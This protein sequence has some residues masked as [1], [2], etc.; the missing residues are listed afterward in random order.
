MLAITNLTKSSLLNLKL[1]AMLH[2]DFRV[3]LQ[4]RKC[5]DKCTVVIYLKL[6]KG[7]NYRL[8]TTG[9]H[10]LKS[11]FNSKK[12]I[13][14]NPTLNQQVQLQVNEAIAV[15]NLLVLQ[16]KT[17]ALD[18]IIRIL[19]P[20]ADVYTFSDAVEDYLQHKSKKI[21][22]SSFAVIQS[23]LR[24]FI[25]KL[26]VRNSDIGAMSVRLL[27]DK[28]N[29]ICHTFANNTL[30]GRLIMLNAALEKALRAGKIEKNPMSYI[31]YE[32]YKN[33]AEF[34]VK[35]IPSIVD[36]LNCNK[37]SNVLLQDAAKFQSSTALSYSDM[38]LLDESDFLQVDDMYL[39]SSKRK[40]TGKS[41]LIPI[42]IATKALFD[43]HK[44]FS[45]LK[46]RR[47][48]DYLKDTYNV[49][50]HAL[51]HAKAQEL[52]C[53]GLPIEALARVLG[54][55]STQMTLKYAP[56]HLRGFTSKEMEL[57]KKDVK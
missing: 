40:K 55:S 30:R 44:G 54:H 21:K 3:R 25:R 2:A 6:T 32:D 11:E 1:N 36:I 28:L 20:V 38:I 18:D 27:E 12:Q 41:F 45:E 23:S 33:E 22:A 34:R 15:C 37:A 49:G 4:A 42:D 43:K 29:K 5:T 8:L 9:V 17:F 7:V 35:N 19:R 10:C 53:R 13:I 48:Y 52:L 57:F 16:K 51:R 46:Y 50:T 24:T 31:S 56:L 14:S 39:I 26:E 47:Y